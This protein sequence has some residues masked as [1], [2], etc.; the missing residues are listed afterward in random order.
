MSGSYWSQNTR[1]SISVSQYKDERQRANN[2]NNNMMCSKFFLSGWSVDYE[3]PQKGNSRHFLV[4]FTQLTDLFP[5]SRGGGQHL[6]SCSLTN[7]NLLKRSTSVIFSPLV[8]KNSQ[9]DPR[10]NAKVWWAM[11]PRMPTVIFLSQSTSVASLQ[12]IHAA[13]FVDVSEEM[14]ELRLNSV[15]FGTGSPLM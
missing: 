7:I 9:K 2:N 5:R 6:N 3:R 10:E 1:Y 14:I 11:F 4:C 8:T 13:A 15:V 12:F